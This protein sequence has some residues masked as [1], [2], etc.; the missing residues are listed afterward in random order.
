MVYSLSFAAVI[1]FVGVLSDK[2]GRRY[3]GL[4]GPILVITGMAVF[5]T[6]HEMPVAIGGMAIAGTGAGIS[7]VIGIS[8]VA[9]IVPAK[10]RGKIIGSIYLFF[11]PMAPAP[12]YGI[13]LSANQL[14]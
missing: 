7:Q 4:C 2:L 8:G 14:M 5:G 1:P 3:I 10:H 6:A 11:S 13:C 9:E 12:A